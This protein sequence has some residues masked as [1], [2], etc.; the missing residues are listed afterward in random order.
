MHNIQFTKLLE[1]RQSLISLKTEKCKL[2]ISQNGF[3]IVEILM[4][5]AIA[6]LI[7]LFVSNLPSSIRLVGISMR[8]SVARDIVNNDIEKL[9]ALGYSNLANGTTN[10]QDPR[11]DSLPEAAALQIVE[12]CP[13]SICPSGEQTKLVTIEVNWRETNADQNVKAV[14]LISE[15]GLK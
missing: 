13:A 10:I 11:L 14:T 1:K 2:N 9:R 6:G 12:D 5:V 3:A 8:Q 15:G 7:V 4:A